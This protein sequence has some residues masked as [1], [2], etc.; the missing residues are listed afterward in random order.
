VPFDCL[1]RQTYGPEICLTDCPAAD[2]QGGCLYARVERADQLPPADPHIIDVAVLDMHHG[3]PNLGHDSI[4]YAIQNAV[5]DL[6]PALRAAGLAFRTISYEIR[7]G[8]QV[9]EPPGGRHAIYIGTGGPGHLDPARNDGRSAGSQGI[10]EDAGW[11]AP[12]FALFEA[13]RSDPD[14]VL[15]AVCHTFGV[16][17]RSLGVG[18]AVLRG[19][20]KGGKSAG[21]VDNVLTTEALEH[22]WFSRFSRE[23]PDRRRFRVLDSRLYDLVPHGGPMP[24]GVSVLAHEAAR[25]GGPPGTAVTMIEVARAEGGTMPR[26]LGVNHH[27]EIV[28]RPRQLTILRKRMERGEVTPEWF[29]ERAAALTQQID[30]RGDESLHLTASYTFLAPLRYHLQREARRRA[31]ALGRPLDFDA[32][33]APLVFSPSHTPGNA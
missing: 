10:G 21:V 17:C 2:P 6:Q 19:P 20:E 1:H 8:H 33:R 5:C 25:P 18:D 27:P 16:L 3:W 29:A 12:V 28:N 22:P 7:R 30:E 32:L 4:V 23:L 15:L 13:I 24:A 31:A 11:Q 9:P 26:I 14:A